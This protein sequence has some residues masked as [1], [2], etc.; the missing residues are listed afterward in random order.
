MGKLEKTML[1]FWIIGLAGIPTGMLLSSTLLIIT[2]ILIVV[3]LST[4]GTYLFA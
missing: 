1:F 4:V 2:S 3:S